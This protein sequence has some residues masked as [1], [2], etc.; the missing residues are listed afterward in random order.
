METDAV[1]QN[2]LSY[3]CSFP[4]MRVAL[5]GVVSKEHVPQQLGYHAHLPLLAH[6]KV[7]DV[8]TLHNADVRSHCVA[9]RI[10]VDHRIGK[11]LATTG[12]HGM[13]HHGYG[14]RHSVA[15]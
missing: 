7:I 8:A 4:L 15:K 1:K 3:S 5:H 2:L 13:A 12:L 14:I 6:V 11:F 9:W 10:A